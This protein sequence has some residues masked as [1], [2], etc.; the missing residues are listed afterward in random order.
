MPPKAKAKVEHDDDGQWRSRFPLARIKKIMQADDDVGKVAQVVPVII[1]K[2]LE[3]FMASLVEESAGAAVRTGHKRVLPGHLK[4]AITGNSMFDFLEPNVE[5]IPEPVR[6]EAKQQT[7]DKK[8]RKP[9]QKKSESK[10]HE[11]FDDSRTKDADGQPIRK[12]VKLDLEPIGY[13]A[14]VASSEPSKP[15]PSIARSMSIA[16]LM[17]HDDEP[18]KTHVFPPLDSPTEG[19]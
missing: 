7:E 11:S 6:V 18:R 17:T 2:G 15:T 14:D 10:D 16:S 5:N 19:L 9:K 12:R 13:N 3:L 4:L 1:S 8:V